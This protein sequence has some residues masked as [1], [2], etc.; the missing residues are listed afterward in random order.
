M[1]ASKFSIRGLFRYGF[2][3]FILVLGMIATASAQPKVAIQGYTIDVKG[4]EPLVPEELDAADGQKM[5]K[6]IVQ[7]TGPI[8]EEQKKALTALGCRIG[9]YL[10][11]FAFIVTM[12]NDARKKVAMLSFIHGMVRYKPAYKIHKKLKDDSGAV[13]AEKGKKIK[14]HIRVDDAQNLLLL[15][16]AIKQKKGAVLDAGSDMS[17]VEVDETAIAPLAR[18]EAVVWIEEALELQPMNDTTRWVIQTYESDNTKVWDKG[19]HGEGQIIGIADT[20]IDYDMPWFLDPSGK[21]IGPE[22]RKIIGYD[23]TFGNDYDD[24]DGHGTHVAGTV[25]GDRTPIDGS[26]YANGMAPKSRFFFQDLVFSLERPLPVDLGGMLLTAYDAGARIHTN[27]WGTTLPDNSYGSRPASIDRFMWDHPSFLVLFANGNSGPNEETMGS[28]A[29]AKNVISVGNTENG[30]RAENLYSRSSNGP[31]SDGR[32]KPTV[33]AP[34]TGIISADSDGIMDSYNDGIVAMGGTS[35][36]TPAVAGAAALVRQFF[37]E[38][39]WPSGIA[40]SADGFTPSAALIKASIVNSAQNMTGEYTDGPIPS[41]GQGWGRVNLS[42]T[43][44]FFGDAGILEVVDHAEGLA[45][46]ESWSRG[47]YASLARPLKVTLVWT[48]FPGSEVAERALVNDLD[49]T[50]T[51]P[52]GT[53]T[54]IGNVFDNG[55]SVTGG[56]ADRLN[57]EEQVL[58]EAPEAGTYTIMVNASNIPN[59]PQPFALVITGGSSVTSKGSIA[60]DRDKYNTSITAGI[61]VKDRD[62]D[63]N[64]AAVDQTMVTITSDTDV[65]GEQVTLTE[66]GVETGIFVGTIQLSQGPPATGGNGLLEVAAGDI[67]ATEYQDENDGTGASA[68]VTASAVIEVTPPVI[69][70]VDPGPIT[71]TTAIIT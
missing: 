1:H 34:G 51:G 60:L 45:T 67:V 20:G 71:D 39:Y 24:N 42:N 70:A 63:L 65:S 37:M 12:D 30:V 31:A 54:Y 62:L 14:L 64:S 32:I 27:S 9:N 56:L 19:L 15:L 18:I 5:K 53:T 33:T 66:T 23:E 57:V 41:T 43:L 36:A 6:W 49:L 7:F 55:V 4:Q 13:K 17:H 26:T 35:M 8:H 29:P 38:G 10:P 2:L 58:L 48:D 40:R 50:V 68:L 16:S 11:E 3:I 28:P 61:T 69:T 21:P 44:M 59:G 22:H 25:G 47:Y 52:D 46:T